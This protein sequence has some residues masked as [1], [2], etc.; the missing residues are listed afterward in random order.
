[1]VIQLEIITGTT[2]FYLEKETAVA[3]GKFD[4]VHVGHRRLLEE[5]IERKKSGL[6]ACV[7][8]FE[9]AP[10]VLFGFSDGRELTVK[11]EKRTLFERMGVDILVEFPLNARTSAISPDLFVTDV[12]AKRLNARF[13]AAG[14]DLSFGAGG[15]GD[16]T[17]LLS[18]SQE[19]GYRVK[20]IDKICYQGR[21]VSS[22]YIRSLVEDGNMEM[23]GQLLGMPYVIMGTVTHGNRIGRTLGFPTVNLLPE[24]KKL[25]P[26]NGVYYSQ[27]RY[28]EK[29]YRAISN[30]G[31][32][33]TVARERI[34]GVESY[35]YD[36]DEEIYKKN[37]EV[38]LQH[39]C[40]REKQFDSLEALKR[41]LQEDIAAGRRFQPANEGSLESSGKG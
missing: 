28:G 38:Y 29:K 36:F 24:E 31:F 32:K 16:T 19:L 26:P 8:T 22:T 39:F 5:I 40:R 30:V 21:E 35:L 2:D 37:I 23:A 17:L 12:L 11:E 3:I 41:Q 10:V 27:V 7:F 9:P 33:P 18:Y 34:L 13:V 4:G 20:T 1:M 14:K 6:K 25:L 15:A